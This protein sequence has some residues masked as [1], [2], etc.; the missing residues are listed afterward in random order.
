MEILSV[1]AAAVAAWVFGAVWYGLNSKAWMEATGLTE[2]SIN[3]SNPMPYIVSFIG[4]VL[5]AG[6]TRH[7]M[8]TSGVHTGLAGALTGFGLGAFIAT[9]WIAAN[10]MFGQ[11]PAKLIWIDGVYATGGCTIIGLVLGLL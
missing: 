7:I 1:I 9:P 5:V 2:D 11:K 6:M 3:R 10:V 8:T 4:T